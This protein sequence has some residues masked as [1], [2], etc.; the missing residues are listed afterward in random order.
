MPIHFVGTYRI[1]FFADPAPDASG[2]GQGQTFLGFVTVTSDSTAT[3]AAILAGPLSA[4]QAV[5]AT[6]T[7]LGNGDTSEFSAD[8]TVQ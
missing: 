8:L 3:F 4:G 6:A 2:H 7:F 1:E 5:S